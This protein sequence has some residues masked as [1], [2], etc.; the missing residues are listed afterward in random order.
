MRISFPMTALA[1]ASLIGAALLAPGVAMAAPPAPMVL[2]PLYVEPARSADNPAPPSAGGCAV[3][4]AE[5]KDSRRGP[6]TVGSVITFRAMQLPADREA[7]LRSVFDVGLKARG[8]SPTFAAAGGGDGTARSAGVTTRI[9]IRAVWISLLATNKT[10]SAVFK[11]STAGA[12]AAPGPEKIYR[13]DKT[14]V[15]WWGSQNEFNGFLNDLFAMAL[16]DFAADLRTAC[17]APAAS[18]TAPSPP[19]ATPAV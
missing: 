8:F 3:Q 19:A 15:N 7:W 10:G 5:L 2:G 1:A 17:S 18:P 4:I 14:A 6:E 11:A 12:G 13:A 9:N 16:D